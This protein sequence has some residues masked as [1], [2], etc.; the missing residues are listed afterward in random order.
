MQF[1]PS[2]LFAIIFFSASFFFA[3]NCKKIYRNINL[4]GSLDRFD[5]K[6]ERFL[7]MSRL[8]FGQ[9]K[10][11]DKPIV[12]LLHLIVYVAF[13]LINIELLEIVLDGFTG[14]HRVLA[15]FLG[16][17]Y[18]FLIGFFEVLALLVIISVLIFWI[19]RNIL[20]IKRFVSKDLTGWP[21]NDA[22]YILFIE[23]L[24]MIL[25]LNM[26]ATDSILQNASYSDLYQS[27]GYFPVS[28]F[29]IPIYDGFSLET[30]HIIER[31]SWWMHILGILFFLN[32]LYYSKHLHIFFAFP[33]TYYANINKLGQFDNLDSVTKEVKLMLDPNADP[34]ANPPED[35]QVNSSLF[36]AR[37]ATDLNWVQLLNAYSCTECGRCSSLCPANQTGKL[38]SPRKVMMD[39]RDRIEEIGNNDEKN[40]NYL[41]GNFITKEEL[42]AC[43]TCN[44]CT[45]ACPINLDPLSIIVDLRRYLVMEES[46]APTELNNMFSNVENNGAPWQFS[47]ADRLKSVSYTH[48][49]LP[50]NREV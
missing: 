12:G 4:G 29:F 26:N 1:L 11:L 20:K 25:F 43:T 36:G 24:L 38:L 19:R 31:T 32:Y 21:K 6:K 47:A 23:L 3:N 41:L 37:D 7:K 50:T 49:T 42:W 35:N 17:F 44:A 8:A 10:M 30:I 18:N 45:D 40:D 22:D 28:Q 46:S 5:N 48:L 27:Y 33:S 34:F 13:I 39:T 16:A 14:K 9:S 15:P 2:I